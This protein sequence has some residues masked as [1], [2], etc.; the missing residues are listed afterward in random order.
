MLDPTAHPYSIIEKEFTIYNNTDLF[1]GYFFSKLIMIYFRSN[2]VINFKI[3]FSPQ[4]FVFA[5]II[6]FRLF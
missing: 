2:Y 4:V 6:A 3:K 5:N 1:A